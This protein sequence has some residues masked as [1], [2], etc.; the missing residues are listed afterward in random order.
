MKFYCIKEKVN[1]V[2]DKM[3][4]IEKRLLRDTLWDVGKEI[5]KAEQTFPK[6]YKE[7]KPKLFSR[8]FTESLPGGEIYINYIIK[9]MHKNKVPHA[10][11]ISVK[12]ET[13]TG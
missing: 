5:T 2:W 6:T 3:N 12:W 11:L 10:S 9:L 1:P 4:G 8:T 7:V 13:T